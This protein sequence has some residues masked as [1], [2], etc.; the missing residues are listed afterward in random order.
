MQSRP[1][2]CRARGSRGP[3]ARAEATPC[4]PATPPFLC[5]RRY[6]PGFL[7]GLAPCPP[8]SPPPPPCTTPP[9]PPPPRH[10]HHSC[11]YDPT[12]NRSGESVLGSWVDARRLVPH[13]LIPHRAPHGFTQDPST[14]FY[15]ASQ[16]CTKTTRRSAACT[17]AWASRRWWSRSRRSCYASCSSGNHDIAFVK[18]TKNTAGFEFARPRPTMAS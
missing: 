7:P 16:A 4:R 3:T 13:F 5:Y 17:T 6:C 11:F 14:D 10:S 12:H 2:D 9:C 15:A 8:Q 18:E 1:R